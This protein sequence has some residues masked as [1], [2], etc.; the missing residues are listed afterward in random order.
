MAYSAW[1]TPMAVARRSG[2][3]L[4]TRQGHEHRCQ[5]PVADPVHGQ[6]YRKQGDGLGRRHHHHRQRRKHRANPDNGTVAPTGRGT[7][8]DQGGNRAGPQA[9][10]R[11]ETQ[12]RG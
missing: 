6:G 8:R 2:A 5:R 1:Y 10:H 3:A 9:H 7:A 4:R 11:Y 12:Y